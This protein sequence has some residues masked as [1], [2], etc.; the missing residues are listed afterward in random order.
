MKKPSPEWVLCVRNIYSRYLEIR[1][2]CGRNIGSK[3]HFKNVEH[4]FENS[5]K[6]ER[7]QI[8]SECSEEIMNTIKAGTYEKNSD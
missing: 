4:A 5:F 8:C 6:Q 7:L 2:Y 1:S 3:N